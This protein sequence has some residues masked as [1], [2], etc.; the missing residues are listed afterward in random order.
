MKSNF[1]VDALDDLDAEIKGMAEIEKRFNEL[2]KLLKDNYS[3]AKLN[4]FIYYYG[5]DLY[6]NKIISDRTTLHITEYLTNFK[7]HWYDPH[8]DKNKD[9]GQFILEFLLC[10]IF[11]NKLNIKNKEWKYNM[12]TIQ[13]IKNDLVKNRKV[14]GI[15]K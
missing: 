7:K 2:L 3:E 1:I 11:K 15:K 4:H 5:F 13:N 6:N 14:M 10:Y 12:I 8:K 9:T